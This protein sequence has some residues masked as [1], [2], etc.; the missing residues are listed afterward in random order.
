MPQTLPLPRINSTN[1]R[2]LSQSL[3][4]RAG[5]SVSAW[6]APG[7]AGLWA[8]RLFLTPPKPRYPSSEFFDL[9]DARQVAMWRPRWRT[10]LWRASIRSK[11]SLLG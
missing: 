11:N 9:I 6:L 2:S 10:K 1:V 7:L 3:A 8:E 5:L 4:R